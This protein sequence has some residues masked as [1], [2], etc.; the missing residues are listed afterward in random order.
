M[1][2]VLLVQIGDDLQTLRTWLD[3]PDARDVDAARAALTRVRAALNARFGPVR[4]RGDLE[5]EI[6]RVLARGEARKARPGGVDA[7]GFREVASRVAG[8]LVVSDH[9]AAFEEYIALER[10]RPGAHVEVEKYLT[11]II[12]LV[13]PP[14]GLAHALEAVEHALDHL[15]DP[16]R[17]DLGPVARASSRLHHAVDLIGSAIGASIGPSCASGRS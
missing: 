13:H 12:S 7:L 2:D 16:P 3:T 6:A 9:V 17:P 10:A 11:H 8:E 1:M 14:T 4:V 5:R 15:D